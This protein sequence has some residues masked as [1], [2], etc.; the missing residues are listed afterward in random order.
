MSTATTRRAE[1]VAALPTFT[2]A[3]ALTM[4]DPSGVS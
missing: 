3:A 4:I 1:Y 2:E